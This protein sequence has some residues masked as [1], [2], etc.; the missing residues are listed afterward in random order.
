MIE[1]LITSIITVSILILFAIVSS[2]KHRNKKN[3][4]YRQYLLKKYPNA[5]KNND[6][7]DDKK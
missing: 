3:K 7:P 5:F 4:S 6:E 2:T 1:T